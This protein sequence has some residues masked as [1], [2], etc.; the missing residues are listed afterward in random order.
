MLNRLAAA[1]LFSTFSALAFAQAQKAPAAYEPTVGQEGKD[2]VWVPTPQALVDKMLDMA[3][4][5]AADFVM[6]LGSGDG[7]TVITAAK[8]GAR[9]V[10]IEYNPDMVAL[11]Q[12]NAEKEGVTS[13]AS[14]RKADLFE[15]DLSQATVIT[16]FL[17]PDI[18]LKLRPKILDLKPGTRVVSNTFTMG[19]WK[20][21]ETA[22]VDNGCS[23]SWC[24]ALF[25]IVPAK[26]AGSYKIPQGDLVL[27]QEF[28]MLS[29][30]LRGDGKTVPVQGRVRGNE[31]SFTAGGKSYK[32]KLNG[33]QL[34][35]N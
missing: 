14:F 11:S 32:G 24:T 30:T 27:K 16:M 33:K 29:G 10:G 7:R 22:T 23:S 25:W 31:I 19:E 35:L 3:K 5:T 13:R 8:R 4:V 15:T 6:D 9:A 18:N 12:K 21:D 20:A 28:Q 1:V 26:V 17:L 34:Q 2:V